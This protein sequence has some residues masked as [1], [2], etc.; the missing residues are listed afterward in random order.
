MRDRV[1]ISPCSNSAAG[2]TID[3]IKRSIKAPSSHTLLFLDIDEDTYQALL[4]S[5]IASIT[6]T[7]RSEIQGPR[8]EFVRKIFTDLKTQGLI[9][10]FADNTRLKGRYDFSLE[11]KAARTIAIDVKGGEGNSITIASRPIHC[12]EYGIWCHFT[13]SLSIAPGIQ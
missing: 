3:A 13:G 6:G 11:T 1:V 12:H 4:P 10:S 2:E 7:H 5:A 8:E 9:T